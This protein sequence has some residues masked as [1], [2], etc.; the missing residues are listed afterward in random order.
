MKIGLD[1]HGVIDADPELFSSVSRRLTKDGHEIHILT[2]E[3]DTPELR[4]K[5]KDFKIH[6]THLLSITTYHKSIGTKVTYDKDGRPWMDDETWD[7]T[8]GD[9]CRKYNIDFHVDDS[10]TYG[11]YFTTSYF[12]FKI[13][14]DG[15]EWIKLINPKP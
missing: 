12:K 6:Y 15:G 10:D 4:G 1:F 14:K 13:D 2:G 5:L 11:K 7:R 3:E 9:Y 8:K